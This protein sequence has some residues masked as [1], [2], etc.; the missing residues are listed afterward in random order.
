MD[1]ISLLKI[2]EETHN[3]RLLYL[4]IFLAHDVL[5]APLPEE[6][7]TQIAADALVTQFALNA[8]E[9]LF[10]EHEPP[11]ELVETYNITRLRDRLRDK[12]HTGLWFVLTPRDKDWEWLPLPRR[13]IKLHYLIR[14]F[15]LPIDYGLTLVRSMP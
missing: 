13:L 4:G 12:I 6:V 8:Q 2:A 7:I 1:W 3:K 5:G 10:Q 15:R 9:T 11:A 14:M